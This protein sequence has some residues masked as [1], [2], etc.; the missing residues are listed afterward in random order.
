M[1]RDFVEMLSSA[2][3]CSR[4]HRANRSEAGP[5]SLPGLRRRVLA[6]PLAALPSFGSTSTRWKCSGSNPT[7][8]SSQ[9]QR[10]VVAHCSNDSHGAWAAD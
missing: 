5:A 9:T 4:R 10:P 7:S 8:L 3:P 6:K 1:N 2:S